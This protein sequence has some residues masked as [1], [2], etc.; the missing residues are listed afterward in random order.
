MLAQEKGMISLKVMFWLALLFVL[1]HVLFKVVPM[2]MD[3]I[4]MK[5]AMQGKGTRAGSEQ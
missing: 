5:D 4:Q 2:G 3:Y 1:I